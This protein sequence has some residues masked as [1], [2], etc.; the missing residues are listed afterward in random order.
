MRRETDWKLDTYTFTNR[1]GREYNEDFADGRIGET[2]AF[3]VLADGLG[4][5][6]GGALASRCIVE[7]LTAAW[8]KNIDENPRKDW[9]KEQIQAAGNA[10]SKLQISKQ[11]VMKSTVAALCL[12]GSAAA[13]AHAGDSRIYY[14]SQDRIELLT[15]DHSVTF[16]KYKAGEITK[17]AMNDDEDRARLLRAI[18]DGNCSPD[19]AALSNDHPLLPG[20]AFLLCTDGFWEHLYEEEILIDYLKSESAAQWGRLMMLRVMKRMRPGSDNLTFTAIVTVNV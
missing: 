2:S 11:A 12:D 6:R 13:W 9:L 16:K 10:L 15:E 18:G 17:N 19:C 5:H 7:N 8:E 3:F 20:D 1:G 4:G 14:L